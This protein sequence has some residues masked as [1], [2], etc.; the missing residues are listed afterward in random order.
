MEFRFFRRRGRGLGGLLGW[1]I[2]ILNWDFLT[3]RMRRGIKSPVSLGAS[4][5][6][7]WVSSI[8]NEEEKRVHTFILRFQTRDDGG[9]DSARPAAENN[10]NGHD[11]KKRWIWDQ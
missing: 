7:K 3:S 11:G 8:A 9:G 10:W 4:R 2:F 1:L 6:W 5:M